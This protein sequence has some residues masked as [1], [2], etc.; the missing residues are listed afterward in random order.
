M[1]PVWLWFVIAFLAIIAAF[2]VLPLRARRGIH[3]GLFNNL[4]LA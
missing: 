2:I 1:P 4:T 3:L